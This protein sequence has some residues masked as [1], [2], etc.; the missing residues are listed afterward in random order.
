MSTMLHY[1]TVPFALMV[2][3]NAKY[4]TG[5]ECQLSAVLADDANNQMGLC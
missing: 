3:L 1:K 2:D 5:L 4:G